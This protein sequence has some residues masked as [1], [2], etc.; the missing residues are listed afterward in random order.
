MST[1]AEKA[2]I[3]SKQHGEPLVPVTIRV[4][5]QAD[6]AIRPCLYWTP[7]GTCYKVKPNYAM[8]PLA[9]LKD[10]GE[11][12]R[13]KV[14]AELI[15]TP[16]PDDALLH[17]LFVSYLYLA[18]SWFCGKNIVDERYRHTGKE[19]IPV[20]LDIFPNCDYE[21]VYFSV[22]DTRYMVENTIAIEPYGNFCAGGVGVRHKVEAR[23]VNANDDPD[24][25]K[26]VRRQAAIYFEI[27]KWFAMVKPA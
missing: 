12:L 19:Y 10:R 11:G 15:E 1:I 25:H 17:T 8:T 9:F 21:L 24:P 14:I 20:T 27:N 7:D 26:S 22:K 16:E 5:W 2:V 3:Y 13:F 23:Q 6:G 4:E 18:D